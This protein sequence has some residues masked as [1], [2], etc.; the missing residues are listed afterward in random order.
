MEANNLDISALEGKMSAFEEEG[1]T[2]MLLAVDNQLA[3]LIA[4]ADTL[5]EHS[6]DAV[7]TLQADGIG[8]HHDYRRQPKNSQSHRSAGRR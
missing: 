5:K 6:A 2:A 7:K 8:S 3:G 4:V 1:K